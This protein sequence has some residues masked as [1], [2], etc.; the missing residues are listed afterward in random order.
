MQIRYITR[1]EAFIRPSHGPQ[2]A[3][4][5]TAPFRPRARL[6]RLLGDELISDEVMAVVEL[7]KNAYDADASTVTIGLHDAADP[8]RATIFVRDDGIG[9]TLDTV[10]SSWLEPATDHK[11][12]GG[13]KRRTPRGR[14]P[15]GEKGVGRFAADKLGAELELV[16]RAPDVADEVRLHVR[17]DAYGEAGYLD[18]VENRWERGIPTVFAEPCSRQGTLVC[19][20]RL[21]AVWDA[22]RLSRLRDGLVRLTSPFDGPS[23]FRII[24]DCPDFPELAGPVT[25]DLLSQSAY[26]LLG[27]VDESGR[28]TMEQLTVAGQDV[29]PPGTGYD[30]SR[31]ASEQFQIDGGWRQPSCGPFRVGLFAWDL[32]S[33]GDLRLDRSTRQ[34][35]RRS[36]GVSLYRDGFRVWPYGSPGD[37]WLELN[38]RRVNNP[39]LR[40]STNQIVGLAEI[41][42]DENPDLR[43]R[44]SREGLIDT[45]A[46]HDLKIL[47]VASLSVLEEHRAVHRQAVAAVEPV[48][49]TDPLLG[50]MRQLRSRSSTGQG[51]AKILDQVI[52]AYREQA[53]RQQARE[54]RLIRF[55]GGAVAAEQVTHQLRRTVF[56]T[57]SALGSLR[58][59]P[60]TPSHPLHPP[61]DH[62][63]D[64]LVLLGTQLDTLSPLVDEEGGDQPELLDLR[65]V[66]HQ[67]AAVFSHA[68]E[69]RGVHLV[70]EPPI[71]APSD[72]SDT[73]GHAG[74]KPL[75]VRMA[76]AHLVQ[77]LVHLFENS[78]EAIRSLSGGGR[79]PMIRIRLD[80]APVP[81][82]T[83]TDTGPGIPQ[84]RHETIFDRFF[85]TR[86]GRRGLGLTLARTVLDRYGYSISARDGTDDGSGA[87]IHVRFV[88][89]SANSAP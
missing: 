74:P 68:L 82:L 88:D 28:L 77:V 21:R 20:R 41:T 27:Q 62:L 30:L 32:D 70:I 69:E 38:Q 73:C 84:D 5:G 33:T 43:D 57:S 72:D 7:V 54:D 13:R 37:D 71:V 52:A 18:E 16:T 19:A 80:R 4:S 31:L 56:A 25:S 64:H 89:P 40:L 67:V 15:L 75:V 48:E 78:L 6:I 51:T 81:S 29:V 8:D 59:A 26:R 83:F 1:S 76:R 39:T 58:S 63:S 53:A 65:S 79:R 86:T 2:P 44:T 42:Q 55:L 23:D 46:V 45:P 66:I 9:M 14:Y 11:R 85:S 61:L 35:L 24:L 49:E 87:A 12:R 3:D 17:W 47:V 22:A 34:L 10:L 50:M 36:A 60:A